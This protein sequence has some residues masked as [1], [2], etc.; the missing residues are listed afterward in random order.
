MSDFELQPKRS[1]AIEKAA[2]ESV[3]VTGQEASTIL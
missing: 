3:P 2:S 1:D